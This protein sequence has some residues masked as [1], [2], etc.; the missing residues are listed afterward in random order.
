MFSCSNSVTSNNDSESDKDT[1][2]IIQKDTVII[3]DTLYNNIYHTDST[4]TSNDFSHITITYY[5]HLQ[6]I[7]IGN[8]NNGKELNTIVVNGDIIN[9][10]IYSPLY[11]KTVSGENINYTVFNEYDTLHGNFVVPEEL[12][13]TVNGY[14]LVNDTNYSSYTSITKRCEIPLTNTLSIEYANGDSSKLNKL[15]YG[16]IDTVFQDNMIVM[17]SLNLYG[18]S[19]QCFQRDSTYPVAGSLPNFESKT[20]KS[21]H[22]LE[23]QAQVSVK[24]IQ[25]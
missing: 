22:Y 21:Y 1:L 14:S 13:I 9:K 5:E 10:D 8:E 7:F 17:D 20:M 23:K 15:V 16:S 25:E 12:N 2:V 18:V 24:F 3:K 6:A 11:Y 4:V 19:F